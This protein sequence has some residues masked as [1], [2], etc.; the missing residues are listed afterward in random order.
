[1]ATH[2]NPSEI[3]HSYWV[4]CLE[5]QFATTYPN[6]DGK[7]MMFFPL[8]EMD[9]RWAEACTLYRSGKLV[10]IN[11]MKASTAKQ[12]PMPQRLHAHDEGIIIFYCG[13][14]ESEDNVTEYGRNILNNMRYPRAQFFYKS[15]KPHLIDHSKKYKNMYEINT[16]AHYGN[17]SSRPVSRNGHAY[18]QNNY[19][20][21]GKKALTQSVQPSSYSFISASFDNY[22]YSPAHVNNYET[23]NNYERALSINNRPY[24]PVS[25]PYTPVSRPYTPVSR[26]YTSYNQSYNLPQYDY[27][28]SQ[29]YYGY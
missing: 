18:T 12:N 1:M 5:Q 10:G 3:F 26:P 17:I 14:S 16:Q 29:G 28:S 15:D 25:R 19:M 27:S 4:Y 6:Q 13:P 2:Y 11:S 21:Y 20:Q 9:Q 7:W 23:V 8:A 22:G 24:T